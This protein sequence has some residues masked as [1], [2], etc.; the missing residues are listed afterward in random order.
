MEDCVALDSKPVARRK[1]GSFLREVRKTSGLSLRGVEKASKALPEPV[2]FDWLS[3]AESGVFLPSPEK[4][5]TLSLV[6]ETPAQD[7]LDQIELA[8]LLA[9]APKE[10]DPESL[11]Q[12]GVSAAKRGDYGLAYAAFKKAENELS[13]EDGVRRRHIRRG[14]AN[15]LLSM[16]RY[17]LA[18]RV[19]EQL[20]ADRASEPDVECSALLVAASAQYQLGRLRLAEAT[21]REAVRAARRGGLRD[22]LQKALITL[23]NARF[24]LGDLRR[25]LWAYE[26]AVAQEE[27]PSYDQGVLLSNIGN[28]LAA[29]G[30]H[31]RAESA[32]RQAIARAEEVANPRL[33]A[34]CFMH[35]GTAYYRWG[36]LDQART[37][38]HDAREI[39]ESHDYPV[40][41][42]QSSYYLWRMAVEAG[43][44][45]ETGEL[46]KALKRLR[47][48]V[49]Q[50]SEEIV[51]FDR[52]L[53]QIHPFRRRKG[54]RHADPEGQHP[55][56]GRPPRVSP[57]SKGE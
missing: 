2:S 29:L 24:D 26:R 8:Q 30:D 17:R 10:R 57:G 32:Y 15:A 49:D 16:G 21:A 50:Q 51:S 23:G 43:V 19:A 11:C 55:P 3:K 44:G 41:G 22:P 33:K 38:L 47:L 40:E 27:A 20:L 6:Y 14:L 53:D 9:I 45:S 5:I 28:C 1:L 31:A 35:L 42:F 56:R 25:S 13:E 4:L 18:L 52:Y 12:A 36:R 37:T 48:R 39:A 7:F 46:F 54:A 34:L